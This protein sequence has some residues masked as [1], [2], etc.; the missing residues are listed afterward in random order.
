MKLGSF[1]VPDDGGA[2]LRRLLD[3]EQQHPYRGADQT[4]LETR[5]ARA[6]PDLQRRQLDAE[7]ALYLFANVLYWTDE[8]GR[9]AWR[10]VYASLAKWCMRNGLDVLNDCYWLQVAHENDVNEVF[11]A[12]NL[13]GRTDPSIQPGIRNLG[14][15]WAMVKLADNSGCSGAQLEI[16]RT[17][18]ARPVWVLFWDVNLSGA[19]AAKE[20]K[21]IGRCSQILRP[22]LDTTIHLA[23][24][25]NAAAARETIAK[26]YAD[27]GLSGEQFSARELGSG[28]TLQSGTRLPSSMHQRAVELCRNFFDQVVRNDA[29]RDRLRDVSEFG[30]RDGGLLLVRQSNCPNNSIPL[31]WYVSPQGGAAGYAAPFARRFST[32]SH[33]S[34]APHDLDQLTLEQVTGYAARM[35]A[36]CASRGTGARIVAVSTF[37]H[38]A[39]NPAELADAILDLSTNFAGRRFQG[40]DWDTMLRPGTWTICGWFYMRTARSRSPPARP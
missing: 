14:E 3:R 8:D 17:V 12:N 11:E 13:A 15:L 36:L 30:Y 2:A 39:E 22:G 21:R 32:Q 38:P 7:A 10:E 40:Q 34:A 33:Q 28:D 4:S 31:L 24:Q 20:I 26:V 5:L 16:L 23:S 29:K 1:D 25:I 27:L 19:T 18:A 9:G 35:K 37:R 6:L